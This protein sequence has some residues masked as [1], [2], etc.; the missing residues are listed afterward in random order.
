MTTDAITL[1][2]IFK[3]VCAL[4]EKNLLHFSDGRGRKPMFSFCQ[5]LTVMIFWH[6]ARVKDFKTFYHGPMREILAKFFKKLPEHSGILKRFPKVFGI[7]DKHINS[8]AHHGKFIIDSTPLEL[9]K[10][11]RIKR[12]KSMREAIGMAISATKIICGFKLH[13]VTNEQGTKVIRFCFSKGSKHD[14]NFLEELLQNCTGSCL[15]DSGYICTKR[16]KRLKDGGM[17]LI[18]RKR[19]NMKTQNTL[20]EKRRLKVRYRVENFIRKL[21]TR[22]GEDFSRFRV[23]ASAKAVVAV[24]IVALNLGF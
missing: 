21:K 9:C 18:V 1:G 15:A 11:V 8:K 22:V 7:L 24:G 19:K 2:C 12:Y 10:K 23:W 3:E 6:T 17:Q 4:C 13:I 20:Q 5:L 16:E 14:V